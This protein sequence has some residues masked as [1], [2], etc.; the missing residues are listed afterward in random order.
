MTT[1][2]APGTVAIDVPA[3][4]LPEDLRS[5]NRLRRARKKL[6][7]LER[8]VKATRLARDKKKLQP[9]IEAA[10]DALAD[11]EAEHEMRARLEVDLWAEL[12][13]TPQAFIWEQLAW[14]REVAQYVR[15]KVRGELGDLEAAKEARMWSDRLGLNP[16][17][18]LRLRWQIEEVDAAEAGGK[19]RRASGHAPPPD[20]QAPDPRRVLVA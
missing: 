2:P 5:S 6:D 10:Q 20:P 19:A 13:S 7:R 1:L 11:L 12:W 18:L 15:W 3:W 17:A 14:P 9:E 8:Q 16:T 4:P